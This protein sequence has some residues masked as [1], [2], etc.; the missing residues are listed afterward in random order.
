M[1]VSEEEL[2]KEQEEFENALESAVF[3]DSKT[4]DEINKELDEKLGKKTDEPGE[5]TRDQSTDDPNKDDPTKVDPVVEDDPISDP[6]DP[7]NSQGAG[8]DLDTTGGESDCKECAALKVQLEEAKT[9]ASKAEQKMSSWEGRIKAANKRVKELEAKLETDDGRSASNDSDQEKIDKF[10]KDFPEFGDVLDVMDKRYKVNTKDKETYDPDAPLDPVVEDKPVAQ[11]DNDAYKGNR[12]PTDHFKAIVAVHP[13]IDEL[14]SSKVLVTWIRKQ[15]DYI[16]P[17]LE[18][19]YTKGSSDEVVKMVT[20]FKSQTG[21][22]SQTETAVD[23]KQKKLQAMK[24]TDGSESPGPKNVNGPDKND[25]EGAAKE[26][27]AEEK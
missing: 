6:S 25:F 14:T 4:D 26:A 5:G 10:R 20:E 1:P 15:P 27:F 21:W 19:V 24:Q 8:K 11:T 17:H 2:Q 16:R 22:K 12:E 3:D 9:K 7:T 23:P 18:K 13:D